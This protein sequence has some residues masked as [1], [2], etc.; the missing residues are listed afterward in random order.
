MRVT[1]ID[2]PAYTPPYDHSLCA[3]L[4]A[5]GLD[6]EL[7]TARFRYGPAPA[8]QGYRR[9]ECFYRF[10]SGSQIAK[11]AQ[12]PLNMARLARRLRRSSPGVTHFQW[13]PL[14]QLD[15]HLVR[16]FPRPLVLT[17]HDLLPREAGPRQRR[18]ARELFDR[19]DALIV[20]S[21]SGRERM[22][23][24]LGVPEQ[25]VH[26]IPHG[27]FDYL[28]SL[29]NGRPLD[30]AT[31]D[32]EGRKMVLFFGLIRPYKGVDLLIEAF[33]AAPDAAVL[34]VAGMPRMSIEPLRK[35]AGELGLGDR[36]RFVAR[37]IPDQE[38]PAY[39]ERADLVVLPYRETEQS[40]VLFTSLA[41][42]VPTIATDVGGFSE[43]GTE[44][45]AIRL[46]PP[47]DSDA[48]GRAIGEL[49]S[50]PAQREQ[51]AAAA[52]DAAAGPYSWARAAELTEQLYR[53]LGAAA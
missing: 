8:A 46:V 10:G 16:R 38:I 26:V 25:M 14:P 7:A 11:A 47:G 52:R 27:S 5:R 2:P 43:V 37:F 6:V 39:F 31:G 49:L 44:Q 9:D 33:A 35:R 34:V 45:Q 48:L 12:H 15:R 19:M 18:A 30:P 29:G 3:A 41:F 50:D 13:L 4:A 1:V 53:S 40:G 28:T 36:V 23:G 24:D 51:L 42:G 17:A 20:H 21:Q 32:L 22:V